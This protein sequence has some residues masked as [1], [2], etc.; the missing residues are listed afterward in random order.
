MTTPRRLHCCFFCILLC[1]PLAGCNETELLTVGRQLLQET[2]SAGSTATLSETEIAAGLREALRVGSDRV[3][4]QLGATD[5]F[6]RDPQVHIPLPDDLLEVRR[7]LEK[8]GMGGLFDDLELRLNRAAEIATPRAKQLFWQAITDMTLDDAR[9]ILSGQD[10]AATRYFER[11]MSAGLTKAMRPLVEQSL[12][13]VGA[14]KAFNKVMTT[15]RS[16]PFAPAV[17][18]DISG[19]VVDR[20]KQG[21]FRYLAR[22]EAAIRHDPIKRTT[23]LLRRVFA[24]Q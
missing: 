8:V 1:L 2:S 14:I 7:K 19:Y 4:M 15:Y 23:A 22:E 11:Q 18:A 5:G 13:E 17:K 10:D 12:D 9:A 21:I 24:G 20:G 6:L 3:V 16:L